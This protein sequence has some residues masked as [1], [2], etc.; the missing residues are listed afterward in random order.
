MSGY[1][2]A[3]EHGKWQ[4]DIPTRSASEAL[5][6]ASGWYVDLPFLL[7]SSALVVIALT[8]LFASPEHAVLAQESK[9]APKATAAPLTEIKVVERVTAATDRALSYL[10]SKQRPDGGW[11]NNHAV[12]AVSLLAFL[13]RGHVPGRGP[14]RDVLDRGKKYLL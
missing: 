13:G 12:N 11:H 10:A 5:A 1:S 4:I 6:G 9:Q 8:L 3:R 2:S 7:R 14:Y